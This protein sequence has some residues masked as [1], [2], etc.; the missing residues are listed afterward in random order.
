M[1]A[2]KVEKPPVCTNPVFSPPQ[3]NPGPPG[4]PGSAGKDGPKGARGDA[5]PPGRAGDPGLQG[6][7][8]PPGEKG[9]PGE[10][11]P[12]VRFLGGR[13]GKIPPSTLA[14]CCATAPPGLIPPYLCLPAGSRRSPRSPRFG[15][16]AWHRRSSRP[17]WRERLPRAAGAIGELSPPLSGGSGI[18]PPAPIAV[19][20]A[21]LGF[22]D[23]SAVNLGCFEVCAAAQRLLKPPRPGAAM[24]RL[25]GHQPPRAQLEHPRDPNFPTRSC[26]WHRDRAVTGAYLGG[27]SLERWRLQGEGLRR[28]LCCSHVLSH[29]FISP[30]LLH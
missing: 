20:A 24:S 7:A 8:G 23:L 17:A 19:G 14:W 2:L 15:R 30:P 29:G 16:T 10:D 18:P 3:G 11:G 21:K 13:E 1:R 28:D 9:E 5:G 22:P 6:P 26:R 4:P 25:P 27:G 12:A